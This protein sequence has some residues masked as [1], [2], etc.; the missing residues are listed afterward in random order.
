ML[1]RR[2]ALATAALAA[3]TVPASSRAAQLTTPTVKTP[4]SF[5]V[6]SGAVDCHVH[7]IPDPAKFPMFAGRVYS[8]PVATAQDLLALQHAL[9]MDHVVIV[10]PSVYG[11]GGGRVGEGLAGAVVDDDAVAGEF[12]GDA[13]RELA[14]RGDEGGAGAAVFERLAQGD[15]DGDGFFLLIGGFEQAEAVGDGVERVAPEVEGGGGEHGAGDGG[16]A[17]LAVRGRC[18]WGLFAFAG[19]EGG[20]VDGGDV[21]AGGGHLGEEVA[22]TGLGVAVV[23]VLPDVVG[24]G[25]V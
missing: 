2:Q 4:V 15:G 23:E 1:T 5:S 22:E 19:F 17:A 6:P 12:G 14:V 18:G 16:G 13:Q 25:V 9:H 21:A 20:W 10:T 24:H 11:G 7:V 3:T 8:P